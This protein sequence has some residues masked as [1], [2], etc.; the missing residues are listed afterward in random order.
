MLEILQELGDTGSRRGLYLHPDFTSAPTFLPYSEFPAR[1]AAAAKHLRAQGIQPGDRVILPFETREEV[2]FSF[3]G[4]MEVGAVPLSV[5]PYIL[6]TP[7]QSYRE[8]L[9]RISERYGAHQILDTP[10]L[11]G[12][13]LPMPRVSLNR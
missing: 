12:L 7:R 4:L 13:T 8:F 3:F 9:T 5:K 2:I 11:S 1:V 6:S 10:S